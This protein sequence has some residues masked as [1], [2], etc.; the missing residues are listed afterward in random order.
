MLDILEVPLLSEMNPGGFAY[1]RNY[2]VEFDPHSLWYEAS[3]TI[4]SHSLKR[5][6]KTD[7]HTFT[8]IPSEIRDALTR[9][10]LNVKELEDDG[11]L[12]IIDSFSG[13]TLLKRE[14]T[15]KSTLVQTM[16]KSLNLKDWERDD[17]ELLRL[18]AAPA[19]EKKRLH[20]DDDTSVIVSYNDEKSFI[21]HWRTNAVPSARIFEWSILHAT[22]TGA[23]SENFYRQFESL[24][25]G[26]IDFRSREED[27]TIEQYARIRTMRGRTH[28]S[29]WRRLRL[30]ENGEVTFDHSTPKAG[31][32]GIK[33]WLKG[34]KK[35][36]T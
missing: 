6:I 11:K 10:G 25:D 20:I 1:G 28:E 17:A 36:R 26:I 5:G 34:P 27:E 15:A 16:E 14:K 23:H 7:Y 12:R 32:L 24:C 13:T 2:L 22:V 8:H 30:L 18:E 21:D 29:R 19:G 3:L 35:G 33:G 4:A 31:G 9:L